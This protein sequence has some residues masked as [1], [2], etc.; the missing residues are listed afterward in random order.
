MFGGAGGVGRVAGCHRDRLRARTVRGT[1]LGRVGCVRCGRRCDSSTL[2]P[3]CACR[4]QPSRCGRAWWSRCTSPPLADPAGSGPSRRGHSVT[5]GGCASVRASPCVRLHVEARVWTCACTTRL[6]VEDALTVL[7]ADA[8]SDAAPAG[9][10][11]VVRCAASGRHGGCGTHRRPIRR[12]AHAA[13]SRAGCGSA[14]ASRTRSCSP[15]R[16]ATW[17]SSRLPPQR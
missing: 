4:G 15:A 5:V 6:V 16:R 2:P 3:P 7:A 13:P 9:F 8:A 10:D 14:P 11:L 12:K 17:P 1:F